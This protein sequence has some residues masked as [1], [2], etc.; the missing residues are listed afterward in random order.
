M[1][2]YVH[3]GNVEGGKLHDGQG[4]TGRG[5][6]S[7]WDTR[8]RPAHVGDQGHEEVRQEHEEKIV[9]PEEGRGV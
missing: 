9:E 1:D 5:V 3:T 8:H 4:T 7:G 2:G 6:L